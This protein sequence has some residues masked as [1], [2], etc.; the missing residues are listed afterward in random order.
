MEIPLN[1][2]L[3]SFFSDNKQSH[4]VSPE[5]DIVLQNTHPM[6]ELHLLHLVIESPPPPFRPAAHWKSRRPGGRGGGDTS[7]STAMEDGGH[8]SNVAHAHRELGTLGGT[9]RQGGGAQ[10][11][12]VCFERR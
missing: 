6:W 11:V 9:G 2:E 12:R 3:S 5:A 1:P 8:S 4:S 10:Q 7:Q